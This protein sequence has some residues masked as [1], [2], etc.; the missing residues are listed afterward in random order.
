MFTFFLCFT[1][2]LLLQRVGAA[3]GGQA[4]DAGD[5][6]A[7]RGTGGELKSLR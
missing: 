5:E 1:E 4:G 7:L 2:D 6:G 3:D